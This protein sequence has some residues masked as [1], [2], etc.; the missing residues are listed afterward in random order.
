MTKHQRKI[1][2]IKQEV[3]TIHDVELLEN[4][5]RRMKNFEIVTMLENNVQPLTAG[6]HV[7]RRV[8]MMVA[9]DPITRKNWE[10][11]PC[12]LSYLIRVSPEVL[13]E[14]DEQTQKGF[15]DLAYTWIGV[16]HDQKNLALALLILDK[17]NPRLVVVV[18][19]EDANHHLR[20]GGFTKS[21]LNDFK[22]QVATHFGLSKVK[23]DDRSDAPKRAP[24]QPRKTIV[25]SEDKKTAEK[26]SESIV[27]P[28]KADT[29]QSSPEAQT[30]DD[31]IVIVEESPVAI[32]QPIEQEQ[33]TE[34]VETLQ[35]E[36]PIT[37]VEP[38]VPF[39]EKTP[40]LVKSVEVEEGEVLD[41]LN[42][43]VQHLVSEP[44]KIVLPKIKFKDIFSNFKSYEETFNKA[45]EKVIDHCHETE[46][47]N[48]A[49]LEQNR[50]LHLLVEN[51]E[52]KNKALIEEQNTVE[53]ALRAQVVATGE[54]LEQYKKRNDALQ[55]SVTTMTK[56]KSE[57][58]K[59]ISE[60]QTQHRVMAEEKQLLHSAKEALSDEISRLKVTSKAAEAKLAQENKQVEVLNASL[61]SKEDEI[62][63]L[64]QLND[65]LSE[66]LSKQAETTKKVSE[67]KEAYAQKVKDMEKAD[68]ESLEVL[69]QFLEKKI[70]TNRDEGSRPSES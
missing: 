24:R 6:E 10:T 11:R 1:A 28:T 41:V 62:A 12:A 58:E 31:T 51:L 23:L 38:S 13:D 65:T 17:I 15:F 29:N 50:Q 32:A 45:N 69:K 52:L 22:T 21:F 67:E 42:I 54:T 30:E 59:Q 43:P 3:L 7:R 33:L 39:I 34:T 49:L 2:F 27:T 4:R 48:I 9:D 25:V 8:G 19:P 68:A 70:T 14:L 53:K 18:I 57:Q 35:T 20:F 46:R 64:K 60:L 55:N 66:S 26:A 16:R 5:L 44:L 36:K 56:E 37:S 40:K 47:K 63:Q 61:K